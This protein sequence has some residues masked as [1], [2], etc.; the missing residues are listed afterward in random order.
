LGDKRGIE[1]VASDLGNAYYSQKDYPKALEY[2]LNALKQAE[3]AGNKFDVAAVTGNI[4][5]IYKDQNNYIMA[6]EYSGRALQLFEALGSKQGMAINLCNIGEDYIA[7]IEDTAIKTKSVSKAIELP[8][9]KYEPAVSIPHGKA[10]LLAGATDYLQRGLLLLR[11]INALEN[12]QGCYDDLSEAYKLKGDYKKALEYG[13]SSKV[14][15]DSL[16][17]EANREKIAQLENK[18]KEDAD[19]L[20]AAAERRAAEVTAAHRRNYELIGV[21]ALVLALVFIFLLTRNNKLLDIEKK[22]SDSLLLNIL[23]EEVANQLKEKGVA[24]AKH[25]DNVTVLFTDFVNFTEASSHMSPQ[26]LIDELHNCFKKFDE[27]THKYGIEKIKTIGDAY[28]AVAGLPSPDPKHAENV[29]RAATEISAF[30]KDRI[31]KLGNSTFEIRIGV[32]SGSVVAGIVGIRKFAY[33][34]W[35]DTVNTAARMEQKSE[36]GRINISQTTYELVKDKFSCEYRGEI[37]AKGKGVLKMYY[38]S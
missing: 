5:N 29:V 13:D 28:L 26:G 31:A 15:K 25:F 38:V 27:I 16:F 24:E 35:G 7:I 1:T 2:L 11:G 12:M 19:S 3:E 17:S 34:I 9:S 4:G 37:E 21:G 6:V 22:K 32:H 30:M 20:K 36:A 10:A 23:P 8:E 33:D 14:I 18:R